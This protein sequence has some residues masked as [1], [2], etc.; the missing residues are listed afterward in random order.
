M[1]A[2]VAHRE[3]LEECGTAG[4]V[5]G[6]LLNAVGFELAGELVP[7]DFV[8]SPQT[9]QPPG[10]HGVRAHGGEAGVGQNGEQ[11]Q[12]LDGSDA[13]SKLAGRGGI[14]HVAA[15]HDI[16]KIQLVFNE[17]IHF[18]L[19]LGR[20]ADAFHGLAG[21]SARRSTPRASGGASLGRY[22]ETT[23]RTPA[24]PDFQARKKAERTSAWW[25]PP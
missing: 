21:G 16:G 6:H 25:G 3:S 5:A 18:T 11:L 1:R 10:S 17:K 2:Q 23:A 9:L 4:H 20:H 14:V 24:P 19:F 13:L 12:T 22:C 7:C 15:A 8:N